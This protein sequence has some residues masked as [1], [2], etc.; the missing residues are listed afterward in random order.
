M[1]AVFINSCLHITGMLFFGK[2]LFH[3]A[4]IF[5]RIPQH[6]IFCPDHQQ[7]AANVLHLDKFRF[8]NGMRCLG[9]VEQLTGCDH[10]FGFL[11]LRI[12]LM[13]ILRMSTAKRHIRQR[14]SAIRK[15]GFPF[16][17][18]FL[19]AVTIALHKAL[20]YE[21]AWSHGDGQCNVMEHRCRRQCKRSGSRCS[22][23]ADLFVAVCFHPFYRCLNTLQRIVVMSVVF[24]PR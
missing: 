15:E 9:F 14:L 11:G 19:T 8:G 4:D 16:D 22:G 3:P 17:R 23:N 20:P 12:Y 1:R 10:A 13:P 6:V 2:A 21:I 18:P 7:F 5:C 24:F